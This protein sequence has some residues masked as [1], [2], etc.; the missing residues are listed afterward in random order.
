MA[1]NVAVTSALALIAKE[2][3]PVP[4]QAPLQPAKPKPA[5]GVAVSCT[6]VPESTISWQSLG[7]VKAGAADVTRPLPLTW[8]ESACCAV[9]ASGPPVLPPP[10]L[11]FEL[12]PPHA[13]TRLATHA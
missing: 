2:Q 5:A 12:P 3:E 7:Q 8:M 6:V 11:L 10:G 4:V 13:S 1:L 9:P